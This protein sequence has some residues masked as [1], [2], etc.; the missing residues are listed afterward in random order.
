MNSLLK[1]RLLGAA[2]A[3]AATAGLSTAALAQG[4]PR[5]PIKMI[6]PF[7]AGGPTDISARL[8]AGK[9]AD[10]LG[11]PVVVDNRPGATGIL[12]S[13]LVQ[14][15]APDGYT[16][17]MGTVGS[18]VQAPLLAPKVPY[19]ARKDFAPISLVA[20]APLVLMVTPSL[21]A[22]SV[23]EL[24][25]LLKAN[26]GKYT[27][28]SS[29]IGGPLHLA[30]VL[31]EQATGTKALHIP[32]KGSAPALQAVMTGEVAFLFDVVSSGLPFVSSGKTRGLAVTGP[33]RVVSMK[34][35]P[36]MVEAGVASFE[37]YTWNALFAP[38]GTPT[39]VV[40]RLN[41]AAV[42]AARDPQVQ[43]RLIE[44]GLEP[45]GSSPAELAKLVSDEVAKWTPVINAPG[46]K[47]AD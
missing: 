15:A 7:P 17:V 6:V 22:K 13:S 3:L 37:A 39:E 8:V 19:D 29:G 9:M 11:Q 26:P 16:I 33:K 41:K 40:A 1:R 18:H 42:N 2:L 23:S 4:F 28:S 44:L 27:Y 35:L 14:T 5:N 30:G 47:K 25:A 34:D 31:F 32:Y 45:V 36:T 46:L 38:P 24:V 10:D 20:T 12:G 43:A 21:P